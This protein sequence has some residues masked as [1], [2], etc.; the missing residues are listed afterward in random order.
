L[1]LFS[2]EDLNSTTVLSLVKTRIGVGLESKTQ[3][4]A[5][6]GR[7]NVAAL[8]DEMF[9]AL[10]LCS[11]PTRI[12]VLE[13]GVV[14]HVNICNNDTG[15]ALHIAASN[16]NDDAV[17][18]LIAFKADVS[19]ENKDNK[20]P[21]QV[22]QG[23]CGKL[24]SRLET[25]AVKEEEDSTM[26]GEEQAENEI[27]NGWTPLMFAAE[28]GL[29][30]QIIVLLHSGEEILS[31]NGRRQTALHIAA[32]A[33]NAVVIEEL[34]KVHAELLE[35]RD[36]KGHTAICSAARSGKV[37]AVR[38]LIR[39]KANFNCE[40]E[41][42]TCISVL[43]LAT[44][45]DVV[46]VL[47]SIGADG[48]TPL[49]IAVEKGVYQVRKYLQAMECCVKMQAR[50][51]FHEWVQNDLAYYMGLEPMESRW[52]WGLHEDHNLTIS[53][54]GLTITKHSNAPDYSCV[55]G[56]ELFVGG[57][58]R[59]TVQVQNVQTMWI[60]VARGVEGQDLLGTF[61]HEKPC[62]DGCILAFG[63]SYRDVIMF[64]DNDPS[65]TYYSNDGYSSGSKIEFELDMHELSLKMWVN[66]ALSLVASNLDASDDKGLC[67]YAC[68]YNNE[69][70]SILTRSSFVKI[71]ST[72]DL[73]DDLQ[74]SFDNSIWP[75][76]LDGY[77][78]RLASDLSS[79]TNVLGHTFGGSEYF[80]YFGC[81]N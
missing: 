4:A 63:L 24:I 80:G 8:V 22:A 33:G 69:S 75:T 14:A 54:D 27:E 32:Q 53:S 46:G 62:E 72:L 31:T 30:D 78:F 17:S 12:D 48:W 2:K 11:S 1:G 55:V 40:A 23:G 56:S 66:G 20:K 15:T 3:A 50:E 60:G 65:I 29:V 36:S 9:E 57:V 45:D 25:P 7:L 76:D 64:G 47:K 39:A 77:L 19:I 44:G 67:P 52:N 42:T 21:F 70:I 10:T 5:L 16:G 81:W 58:H 38:A 37:D 51:T 41:A 49:M 35:A 28:L 13:Q 74:C 79:Q 73:S 59:W 61:P 6:T 43:E 34:V 71:G 26:H 68:M 18:A